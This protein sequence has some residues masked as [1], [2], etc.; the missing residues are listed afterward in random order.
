MKGQ[1]TRVFVGQKAFIYKKGKVLVLRDPEYQRGNQTG[2][3]FPGGRYRYPGD[4]KDEL[5]REVTEETG[6]KIEIGKPFT[7]WTNNVN[8]RENKLPLFLVGYLCEYVSGEVVLSNEHDKFEWVDE[9][10]YK[11]WQ[12][13]TDYFRALEEYFKI[14]GT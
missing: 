7:I 1:E 8:T 10:S 5:T 14:K 13:D 11:K 12:E 2:L 6:L 9:K 4:P 3:D